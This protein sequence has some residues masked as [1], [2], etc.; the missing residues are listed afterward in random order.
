MSGPVIAL[1]TLRREYDALGELP[2][3][4]GDTTWIDRLNPIE[5]FLE[6]GASVAHWFRKASHN[7]PEMVAMHPALHALLMR[8][9]PPSTAPRSSE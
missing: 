5:A 7:D 9:Y 6:N 1:E 8:A 3:L 2:E 4:P